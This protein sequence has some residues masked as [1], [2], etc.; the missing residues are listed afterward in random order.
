M[1]IVV[2]VQ[3][4]E[5]SLQSPFTLL[6]SLIG[7]AWEEVAILGKFDSHWLATILY[8]CIL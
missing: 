4:S 1:L 7:V 2:Q 8:S 3:V 5:I 6:S